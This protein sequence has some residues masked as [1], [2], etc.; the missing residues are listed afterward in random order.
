MVLSRGL[1]GGTEGTT[2]K[3]VIVGGVHVEILTQTSQTLC[4]SANLSIA[5]FGCVFVPNRR[6]KLSAFLISFL[7]IFT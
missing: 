6:E 5:M 1:R 7:R 2:E 3:Y 4:W